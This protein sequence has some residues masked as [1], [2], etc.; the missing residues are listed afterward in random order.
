MRPAGPPELPP[1]RYSGDDEYRG[2]SGIS[3]TP[4]P[5]P[6]ASRLLR[7]RQDFIA[8]VPQFFLKHPADLQFPVALAAAEPMVF[9]FLLPGPVA[10]GGPV[11]LDYLFP[12]DLV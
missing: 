8:L 7:L 2:G 5:D 4:A 6:D 10:P 11:L 1:Q 12:L 9:E 3:P